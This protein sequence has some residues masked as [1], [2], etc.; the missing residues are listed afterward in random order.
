VRPDE[1]RGA[2]PVAPAAL[3]ALAPGAA[4]APW[5]DDAV[6]D[7]LV[8][9]WHLWQRRRGHRTSTDDVLTAWLA[10]RAWRAQRGHGDS[11]AAPYEISPARYADLGCGIGSVMLM[12]AHALRP[13][14]TAGVEAQAQ[15]VTMASRTVAELPGDQAITL[16]HGDLRAASAAALGGAF[17]LVTGSPPYFPVGAGT[18]SPDPQRE[19]CRFELRG[20]IEVYC[21][22]AARVLAP[23][24]QFAVVFQTTWDERVLSAAAAAGLSLTRRV[25]V[26]MRDEAAGPFLSVYVFA[27]AASRVAAAVVEPAFAIR[28]AAGRVTD[29]YRTARA[30]IGLAT[31]G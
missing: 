23:W 29:A 1:H 31:T 18:P 9:A 19:A 12:T 5:P 27:P 26:K 15:S 14:F 7:P 30:E 2:A 28:D 4:V 25:D 8:G 16:Y 6:C 10:V 13:A 22:A 17:D 11:A 21:A 24:G 20:G 3:A